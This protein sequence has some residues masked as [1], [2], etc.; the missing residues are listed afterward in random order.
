MGDEV[1]ESNRRA[2]EADAA[3]PVSRSFTNTTIN[4]HPTLVH[5][6][7]VIAFAKYQTRTTRVVSKDSSNHT[8]LSYP[9][10]SMASD[11]SGSP[12]SDEGSTTRTASTRGKGMSAHSVHVQ[13]VFQTRRAPLAVRP[14]S[15]SPVARGETSLKRGRAESVVSGSFPST[16][17]YFLR[18]MSRA[19]CHIPLVLALEATCSSPGT[20]ASHRTT[21]HCTQEEPSGNGT[22]PVQAARPGP[23]AQ[24]RLGGFSLCQGRYF[25]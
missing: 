19:Q 18:L 11:K 8:H 5:R 25:R 20:R 4:H 22:I 13:D 9:F 12:K 17:L 15:C 24:P 2:I 21:Q 16:S 10:R 7:S 14:C 23:V 6:S 3:E 1:E